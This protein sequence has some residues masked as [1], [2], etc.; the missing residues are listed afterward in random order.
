MI[1][2]RLELLAIEFQEEKAR[3]VRQVLVAS[4]TLFFAFFGM[5][6]ALLWLV[7]TLP[8][9]YQHTVLGLLGLAFLAGG[10]GCAWWLMR[11]DVRAP[12]ATTIKTLMRD[13]T[14][15]KGGDD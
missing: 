3:I 6:L 9:D 11:N 14:A 7:L 2:T 1:R 8:E 12:F 5:L 4:A 13:E 15:L 10:G